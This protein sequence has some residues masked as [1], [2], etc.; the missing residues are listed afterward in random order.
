M[1]K[2]RDA[3]LTRIQGSLLYAANPLANLWAILID[4]GLDGDQQ[5]VIPVSEM[6][7]VI[8]RSLV[9]LGNANSLLS[10]RRREIALDA[11]H[12]SLRKYAKGDFTEAGVDLFGGRFKEELVQKVEADGALSKAVRIVSRGTKV[13]QSPHT[14]H[15]GKN[16]LFQS[17]T[18]GYGTAF[19]KRFNPYQARNSY[20]SYQGRGRHT[21]GRPYPKKGSVF[22]RLGQ[23]QDRSATDR[24]SDQ[25]N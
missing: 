16:P 21:P 2:A 1:D 14:H 10:E 15:K 9:L 19:G 8:Q 22:E 5:A 20:N 7:D 25:R 18:S 12:P 13:Y 4:Q 23:Q 17:R 11:V 6:L 3:A 24:I